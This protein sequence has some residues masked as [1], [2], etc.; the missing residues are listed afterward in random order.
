MSIL[1]GECVPNAWKGTMWH[2]FGHHCTQT[3]CIGLYKASVSLTTTCTVDGVGMAICRIG[4]LPR[5]DC[6]TRS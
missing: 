1:N 4:C 2:Y 5:W 3:Y 6:P